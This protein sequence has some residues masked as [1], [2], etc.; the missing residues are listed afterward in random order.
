MSGTVNAVE[1]ITG[2]QILCIPVSCCLY[3][4]GS[5][6]A[7]YNSFGMLPGQSPQ[8]MSKVILRPGPPYE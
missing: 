2:M 6:V 3:D 8:I 5:G 7:A 4:G 1:F